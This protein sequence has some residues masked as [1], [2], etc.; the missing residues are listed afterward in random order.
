[1]KKLFVLLTAL[2]LIAAAPLYS[3]GVEVREI[4]V[5]PSRILTGEEI[6]TVIAQ[7]SGRFSGIELLE[8]VVAELNDL[9]F[10]K[11]YP[12]AIAFV[13][14][15]SVENGIVLIELREGTVG[16]IKVEGNI[17][18]T[19][20]YI[21]RYLKLEKGEILNLGNLE[22]NLVSF[23]RWNS[24]ITASS[25]L[26]PGTQAGTTDITIN[27]EEKIPLKAFLTF[28]NYASRALEKVRYG[29]HAL[30]YNLTPLR[31]SLSAGVY[32]SKHI[33]TPYADFSIGLGTRLR[34]G[35]RF[36]YGS[37]KAEA[38]KEASIDFGSKSLSN[39][40]Y[41]S[42]VLVRNDRANMSFN[43]SFDY[44]RSESELLDVTPLTT[45]IL[46]SAR[47]GFSFTFV[48][49]RF[50]FSTSHNAA[51]SK[52]E[53]DDAI[54]FKFDGSAFLSYAF[55]ELI[56]G[57]LN[58]T[59]QVMPFDLYIPEGDKMYIGG[60]STVRGYSEGNTAWGK[61]GYTL[62][63]ELRFLFPRNRNTYFFL[64]LDHGGIFPYPDT[65]ENYLLSFGGGLVLTKG[66]WLSVNFA[67][68]MNAVP[69]TQDI[70]HPAVRCH[71]AATIS[72]P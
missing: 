55:N 22:K 9:Y 66:S 31:E 3:E 67:A 51:G 68:G 16:E 61:S 21:L 32:L 49:D 58:S 52:E 47:A 17:F 53:T 57:V 59:Y 1:M 65:G 35:T 29:V 8:A 46:Y 19:E 64:F 33:L 44:S 18:T 27:T 6:N 10:E 50:V 39:G 4:V 12:N 25:V 60:A 45:N 43:T 37:T 42:F 20:N 24:G 2:F 5:S 15:Q 40:L 7:C 14:E 36:S 56:Y 26:E 48:A 11:G 62:S 13:P 23:N 69:I 63:S 72:T 41:G 30:S 54:Y 34:L 28:D 70:D 71:I 38:I